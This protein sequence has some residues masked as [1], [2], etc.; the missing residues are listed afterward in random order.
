MTVGADL[1]AEAAG[2]LAA[3]L[4]DGRSLKSVLAQALPL[5]P[6]GRDRALLE[7]ICFAALRHRRR[8]EFALS[9]WMEKP[10]IARDGIIHALLLAGLAQIDEMGLSAHAA[11]AATAEAA[12]QLGRERSVGLVNALLRRALRE[13]LPAADTLAITTSH[14]DWLVQTL[15]LDWPQHVERIL[16]ENNRPAPA[17]SARWEHQTPP[18]RCG[19]W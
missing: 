9:R 13:G 8:Y 14:P 15:T 5:W 3:V 12:R 19:R 18:I 2:I 6:D 16:T 7:A 11:V 17:A 1:R 10:L 4:F